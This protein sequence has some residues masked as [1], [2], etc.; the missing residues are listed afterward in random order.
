MFSAQLVF[1]FLVT[2]V[3]PVSLFSAAAP[4]K[5]TFTY[6]GLNELQRC[7]RSSRTATLVWENYIG[8]G[9]PAITKRLRRSS[10]TALR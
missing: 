10:P 4:L 6:G 7:A 2:A 1:L 9:A 3:Y 5:A 8:I